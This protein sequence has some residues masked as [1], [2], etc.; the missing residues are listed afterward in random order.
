[1]PT[2]AQ[3][4]PQIVHFVVVFLFLGVALRWV[5]FW[6]RAARWANPAAAALLLGGT[7]AAAA[8]V[9]SGHDAHGP[10]ERIPGAR[11]AVVEHEE[12]G[13]R[14]RNIFLAVAALELAAISLAVG[15]SGLAKGF[16]L[17][18]AVAGTVGGVVLF[19]T[20][21]HGGAL[22]Y[23][24]AGGVGTRSGKPEDVNHLLVA[25]LY[26]QA[27]L[28]RQ[29]GRREDAARLF[30][31]LGQRRPE[32]PGTQLLV[33][34]SVL[35]DQNLPEDARA[36]LAA[37][38]LPAENAGLRVRQGLLAVD[39]FLALGHPDSARATLETL[40]SAFPNNERLRTRLAQLDSVPSPAP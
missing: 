26:H 5:G 21:E 34:E 1:M 16:R 38:T 40:V 13:E 23:A 6:P 3:L 11:N 2:L 22:V 4:H 30:A 12:L 25:G 36:R 18:S 19:E 37:V 14:T 39:I 10:A 27:Q 33:V 20:A 35:R 7:L 15:R 32:D 17:A 8:A 31:E 9:L 24:Y 28:D 29:A